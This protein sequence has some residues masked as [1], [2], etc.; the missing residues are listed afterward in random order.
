MERLEEYKAD[1]K[2]K[3]LEETKGS[4]FL[5]GINPSTYLTE[6]DNRSASIYGEGKWATQFRSLT[7]YD[8]KRHDSVKAFVDALRRL[9]ELGILKH[10]GKVSTYYDVNAYRQ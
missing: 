2:S 9:E 4:H 1:R 5:R 7:E 8:K 6:N 10:C 3:S